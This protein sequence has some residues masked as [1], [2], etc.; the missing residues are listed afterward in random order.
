ME[1]E[2]EIQDEIVRL[3]KLDFEFMGLWLGTLLPRRLINPAKCS[4]ADMYSAR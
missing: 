2:R 1:D 3:T 4:E